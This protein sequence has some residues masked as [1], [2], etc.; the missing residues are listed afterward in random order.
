MLVVDVVSSTICPLYYP[1]SLQDPQAATSQQ[2]CHFS[3]SKS[4]STST[5][6]FL[7]SKDQVYKDLK[8]LLKTLK[9]VHTSETVA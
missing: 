6:D 4:T 1:E 3:S 7:T 9:R 5:S 2:L 8:G